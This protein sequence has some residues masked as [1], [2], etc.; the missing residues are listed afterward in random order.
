LSVILRAE[1]GGRLAAASIGRDHE[2]HGPSFVRIIRCADAVASIIRSMH[3]CRR[4]SANDLTKYSAHT[5]EIHMNWQ[6]PKATDL[7]FGFEIT[8][9]I[10]NR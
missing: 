4:C 8:M 3:G 10:A 7:R 5:K 9:Y 2:N 6:T 1:Y